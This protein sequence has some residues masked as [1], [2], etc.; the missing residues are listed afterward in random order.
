[1]SP[2]QRDM[3]RYRVLQVLQNNP[4]AS[5]RDLAKEL[6]VSLGSINFC[7]KAFVE[8]GLVKVDNFTKSDNKR[9]YAYYLTPKGVAQKSEITLQF[10]NRKKEEYE[11]LKQE[12]AE[13][14]LEAEKYK[15]QA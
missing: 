14:T 12:I 5:Q 4:S 8:K 2:T 10:L 13:L 6:G 15:K 7:I 9:G 1:M 3:V 11:L